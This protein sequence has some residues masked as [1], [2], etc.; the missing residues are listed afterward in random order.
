MVLPQGAVGYGVGAVGK[1]C[2]L[3]PC[4]GVGVPKGLKGS[5][6]VLPGSGVEPGAMGKLGVTGLEPTG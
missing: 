5:A 2:G 4:P 6:G 1:N 3:M